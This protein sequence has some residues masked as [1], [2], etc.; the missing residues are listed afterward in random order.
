MTTRINDI[1]GSNMRDLID[2]SGQQV[3]PLCRKLG[4]NRTQFNRYLY[5]Q[6][7]PRPDVLWKICQFFE[8]DARIL[9]QP[10]HELERQDP[11]PVAAE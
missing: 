1:F 2:R 8:V 11:P 6:S 4:I 10:L 5:S 7:H 3:A 9:H